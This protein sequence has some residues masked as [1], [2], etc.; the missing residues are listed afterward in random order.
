MKDSKDASIAILLGGPPKGK[1]RAREEDDE[2]EEGTGADLMDSFSEALKDND[3]S[4]MAEAL[5]A[6]VKG[7]C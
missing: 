6:F 3:S 7:Y 5:K 4:A 1:G 2:E